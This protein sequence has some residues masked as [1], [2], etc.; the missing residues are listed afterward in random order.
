MIRLTSENIKQIYAMV[1][2]ETGGAYGIRDEALLASA[3]EGIFQTFGGCELYSSLE[4]KGTRLGYSLVTGH[5]FLDG[6]KRIGLLAMLAFLS[7]NGV[8]LKFSDDEMVEIALG[9]A[10]G[11]VLYEELLEWI[12]RH[13]DSGGMDER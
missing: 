4:K 13:E 11:R 8:E 12:I 7:I 5:A 2:K 3:C 1:V 10:S 9:L 6:N